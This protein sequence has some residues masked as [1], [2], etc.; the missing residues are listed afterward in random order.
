MV[1]GSR[2]S[3]RRPTTKS[4]EE[5]PPLL[6]QSRDAGNALRSKRVRTSTLTSPEQSLKRRRL[7]DNNKEVSHQRIPLRS[8]GAPKRL[9]PVSAAPA[10]IPVISTID[11]SSHPSI[12]NTPLQSPSGKPQYEQIKIIEAKAKASIRGGSQ[13]APKDD[14]R[15]L[16]SEDGGSRAKT[17]LAQYFPEFEE[18]LSLKPLDPG[19]CPFSYNCTSR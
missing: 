12:P 3:L 2:S 14:R 16:R 7:S 17:E 1:A 13:T 5:T 9:T 15:K 6:S 10:P 18:M 19:K 11:L 8:R 4:N